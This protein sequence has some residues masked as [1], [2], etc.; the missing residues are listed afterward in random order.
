MPR[1]SISKLLIP[2][3]AH[4]LPITPIALEAAG[5]VLIAATVWLDEI[6]DL[7]RHIFGAP[8][9]PFRPH[10]A[11]MESGLILVLGFAIVVYT[12]KSLHRHLDRLIILCAWCHRVELGGAWVSIEDFLLAHRAETNHGMCNECE[13]RFHTELKGAA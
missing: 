6:L 2:R 5:F 4:G 12:V 8:A 7:P 10:E 1:P 3:L 9:S 13:A 11:I